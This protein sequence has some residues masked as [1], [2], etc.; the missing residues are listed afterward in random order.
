[1]SLSPAET[2]LVHVEL[3]AGPLAHLQRLIASWGMLAD[4]C[5]SDLLLFAPAGKTEAGEERFVILG[6]VRPTSA[7][8][9]HWDDLIGRLT[10]SI[11]RP[12]VGEAWARGEVVDGEQFVFGSTAPARVQCIPMRYRADGNR[13]SP[14][15]HVVAILSREAELAVGRS[16][17]DLERVYAATFARFAAMI[18]RGEFPFPVDEAGNEEAPRVGDGVMVLDRGRRIEYASP[19]A[20]NALHRLGIHSNPEGM[21]LDELGADETA[22]AGAFATGLPVTADLSG[23]SAV[24]VLARCIPMLDHAT[25]TGALVLL[26]DVTDIRRRDRLLLD[27]DTTI[28]EIHHRVKNNLQ[29]ISSLLRI[30]SRRLSNA[31]ARAALEEADRRIRSIALVHEILSRDVNEVVPLGEVLEWILRSARDSVTGDPVDFSVV[32]DAGSVPAEIA[33]P[34]AVVLTELLQNAVEHAFP[35]S[36]GATDQCV[37]VELANDGEALTVRVRDNGVG[38]PENFS[39]H[40]MS[41][42]GI[43]IIKHLVTSQLGGVL[44]FHANPEGRGAEVELTVPLLQE[45]HPPLP[46]RS[47]RAGD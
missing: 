40:T 41:S 23:A 4:L 31:N 6:Q 20:V 33:T 38:L 42:M 8:T 35:E 46:S 1:M 32:G 22:V 3:D 18:T 17:G 15:S 37:V 43:S 29:T 28:R 21:R 24:T 5:F 25:V 30:Q 34:M 10:D 19:N 27:K 12:L 16:P 2:A 26:R 39:T 45:E 47:R 13:T 9:L 36:R 11:E 14:E 7:R 44:R